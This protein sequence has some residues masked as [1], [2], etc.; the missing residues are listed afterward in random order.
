MI[1]VINNF[2]IE[3]IFTNIIMTYSV[4]KLI[5]DFNGKKKVPTIVKRIVLLASILIVVVIYKYVDNYEDNIKL[6]NSA[7]ATPVC[8]SWLIK[9]I[10][11][12]LGI[13]YKQIKDTI[14]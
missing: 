6:F 10:V 3:I 13:D 11:K 2:D 4:I 8:W 7:I 9:P 1:D 14:Q 12:K 5:D